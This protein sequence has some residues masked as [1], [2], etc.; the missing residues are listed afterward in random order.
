MDKLKVNFCF[1]RIGLK[2][3]ATLTGL[4]EYIVETDGTWQYESA[5]AFVGLSMDANDCYQLVSIWTQGSGSGIDEYW[6]GS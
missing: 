4:R 2:S 5:A 6:S 3:E 1:S